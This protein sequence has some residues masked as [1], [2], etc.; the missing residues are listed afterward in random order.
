MIQELEILKALA[1]RN[2]LRVVMAL[3]RYDELCACQITE[4]LQ[5]TGATAS[6]HLS[7]LQ[8]AGLLDSR[9]EGRWVYYQLAP[10]DG[11]EALLGW[12]NHS[13]EDVDEFLIDAQEL[14][15]IID[16]GREELCRLQRGEKCCPK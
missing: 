10:P 13:F 16:L 8:H 1:D 11:A 7:I 14:E 12:V 6:R 15:K 5:V 3:C 9:K 4:L 2:R